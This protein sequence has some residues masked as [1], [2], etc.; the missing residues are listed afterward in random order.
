MGP[1]PSGCPEHRSPV[2]REGILCVPRL[3]TDHSTRTRRKGLVNVVVTIGLQSPDGNK[4]ITISY[5][6]GIE[7]DFPDKG[8]LLTTYGAQLQIPYDL[9]QFQ[10]S[11]V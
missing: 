9:F 5:L 8:V 3:F 10:L 6:P 11:L 4:E 1:G 7:S 2:C